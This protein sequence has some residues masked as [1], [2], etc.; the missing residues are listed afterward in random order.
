MVINLFIAV[1]LD[2]FRVFGI[3]G[4]NKRNFEPN[5]RYLKIEY[6]KRNKAEG[7]IFGTSR[8]NGYSVEL[9]TKLTGIRFYNLTA[10]S[11]TPY[12]MYRNLRW[13][14]AN[15]KPRMVIFALDFDEFDQPLQRYEFDLSRQEHP[16]VDETSRVLFLWKYLWPHPI[17]YVHSLYGNL[18]K[19]DTWYVFEPAT[20]HYRFPL[21]DRMMA[22]SPKQYVE[23][24]VST[25]MKFRDFRPNPDQLTY[26]TRA[27]Q[28]AR[29]NG[30]DVKVFINPENHR[31]FRS[32]DFSAYA[33]W[34]R[35]VTR[36]AGTV[37]DF[38]G[39]N[40]VTKN[41]GQFYDISHFTFSA[42]SLALYR[43]FNPG[44]PSLSSLR[45]FG[46]RVTQDNL[47]ERISALA[48]ELGAE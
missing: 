22:E 38:S 35:M 48:R 47:E 19:K 16:E 39:L 20:G 42:G 15:R 33:D 30:I 18:I 11:Q 2:P 4:F 6:L 17:H 10:A 5:T 45:D 31:L 40:S 3:S 7:F 24:R 12:E 26:L 23:E 9:A 41:D 46:V 14:I 43:V 13:L 34:L 25:N 29:K 1:T 32:Y 37:W 21:F 8:V 44:H 28:L 27:I 36:T